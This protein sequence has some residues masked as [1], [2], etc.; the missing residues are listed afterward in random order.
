MTPEIKP[1]RGDATILRPLVARW[2]KEADQSFGLSL[3]IEYALADLQRMIQAPNADVLI[4]IADNVIAG[5]M[6]VQAFQSPT[7]P[8]LVANEHYWFVAPEKRGRGSLRMIDAAKEWAKDRGC[9]HVLFN[10]S[11]LAGK[12]ADGVAKLYE[13]LGMKPFERTFIAEIP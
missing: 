2:A 1:F 9:T 6:G 3:V 13:R 11:Y 10:A 12:K 4:L 7:G 8:E 5:F